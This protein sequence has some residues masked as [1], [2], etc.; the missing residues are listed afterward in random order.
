[1]ILNIRFKIKFVVDSYFFSDIFFVIKNPE[2]IK[3]MNTPKL[4]SIGRILTS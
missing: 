2:M 1:M 3:K 4:A